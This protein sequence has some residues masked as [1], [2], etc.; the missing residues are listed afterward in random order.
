MRRQDM[1]KRYLPMAAILKM[2]SN[3]I[4]GY[5]EKGTI[6]SLTYSNDTFLQ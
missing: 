6:F 1:L 5:H 2:T 4:E 3:D